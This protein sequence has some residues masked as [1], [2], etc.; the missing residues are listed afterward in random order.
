MKRKIIAVFIICL[1][2]NGLVSADSQ[3]ALNHREDKQATSSIVG[4]VIN[5]LHHNELLTSL[6][7][8]QENLNRDLAKEIKA[9]KEQK[10]LGVLSSLLALTFIYG[11]LHAMGPGHGKSVMSSWIVARQRRLRDVVFVGITAAASHALSAAFIIGA[12]YVILG[13]FATLSTQQLNM[14][15]QIGATVLVI[16]IG[17]GMII[18][19]LRSKFA[20]KKDELSSP[21]ASVDV[22]GEK[23]MLIALSIGMIPC[24][25][26]SVILIFCLTMGLIWQGILLVLSFAIGMVVT[27]VAVSYFV[28]SV[29]EKI[30]SRKLAAIQYVFTN[31]LPAVGGIVLVVL[32]S[33]LLYSLL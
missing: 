29:K 19:W 31:I 30:A 10:S 20:E 9:L 26:A 32:G 16:V 1:C 24:P 6:T 11:M 33:T 21:T 3:Q 13:K 18:R 12:A 17:L 4:Q 28:W 25:V 14:Y 22:L 7:K 27:L 8:I 2:I 23:P 5:V 15:L